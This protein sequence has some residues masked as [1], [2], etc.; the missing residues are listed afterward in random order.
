MIIGT[1]GKRG[2]GA[3]RKEKS[4]LKNCRRETRVHRELGTLSG[5]DMPG[6]LGSWRHFRVF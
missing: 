3:R 5:L 6:Q 1:E 4:K 2:E